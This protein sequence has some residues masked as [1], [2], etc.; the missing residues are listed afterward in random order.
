MIHAVPASTHCIALMQYALPYIHLVYKIVCFY[1]Y[2]IYG[3]LFIT[4]SPVFFK[5]RIFTENLSLTIIIFYQKSSSFKRQYSSAKY[6][7]ILSINVFSVKSLVS[8][9]LFKTLC[10]KSI[11]EVAGHR[12]PQLEYQFRLILYCWLLIII[13]QR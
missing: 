6:S 2:K 1:M 12:S 13:V 3:K 8:F 10:I 5:I 4:S 7:S 11:F 9:L